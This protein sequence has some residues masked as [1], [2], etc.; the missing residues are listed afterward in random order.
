M[1]W[2]YFFCSYKTCL[3]LN[4]VG[5]HRPKQWRFSNF[6][7]SCSV[8]TTTERSLQPS[9]SSFWQRNSLFQN[10]PDAVTTYGGFPKA[11]DTSEEA[12]F[13]SANDEM[14]YLLRQKHS[15][16]TGNGSR[17]GF[18]VFSSLQTCKYCKGLFKGKT[19][20]ISHERC[21]H[22]GE[23]PFTCQFC[24]KQFVS[25][26]E[27]V[28][29]ERSHTGEKPFQCPCCFKEFSHLGNLRRHRKLHEKE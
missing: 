9:R 20:L 15:F 4:G 27:K 13:P 14:N 16:K 2:T 10:F 29:H 1:I 12:H 11:C 26:A 23:K 8:D 17:R 18:K 28:I 24:P 7:G 19:A 25:K 6:S 21:H 22:T 5:D 3:V